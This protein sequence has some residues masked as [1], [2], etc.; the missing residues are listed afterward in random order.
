M[1]LMAVRHHV[2]D[3]DAWLKV[4]TSV[5]QLQKSGG[6]LE[7][8]IHRDAKDPLEVLV[9]HRFAN[10][11]SAE[12]FANNPEIAEAM[13]RGGVDRPPRIE[14]YEDGKR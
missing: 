6:V 12:A 11:A 9:L 10:P 3:Y 13:K 7:E 14:I 1:T 2:S 5:G 4:Y 8:S